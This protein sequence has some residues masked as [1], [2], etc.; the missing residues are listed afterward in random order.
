[1]NGWSK[2]LRDFFLFGFGAAILHHEIWEAGDPRPLAIL[3]GGLLLGLIPAFHADE[4]LSTGPLGLFL[5]ALGLKVERVSPE[6]QEA[7]REALADKAD[8][9][10]PAGVKADQA[11]QADQG[12]Q[13]TS[14]ENRPS[15]PPSE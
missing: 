15:R 3:I 9:E 1:M 10:D 7:A 6:K 11:G 12:D 13:G 4:S 5:R 2:R 8:R 14:A